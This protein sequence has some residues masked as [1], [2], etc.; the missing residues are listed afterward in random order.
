LLVPRNFREVAIPRK[1]LSPS[2]SSC[3]PFCGP[4]EDVDG[5]MTFFPPVPL[6]GPLGF[7]L[8]ISISVH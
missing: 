7:G 4:Y 8:S 3:V 6:Y 2:T 5:P 1:L